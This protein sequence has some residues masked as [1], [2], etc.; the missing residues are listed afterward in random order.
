MIRYCES[1]VIK[2]GGGL[3]SPLDDMRTGSVISKLFLNDILFP[4]S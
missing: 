2:E 4:Y 3:A 1:G